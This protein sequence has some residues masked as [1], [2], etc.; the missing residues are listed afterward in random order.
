VSLAHNGVLFLDEFAEFQTM[1]LESLRQPI[2]D[3]SVTIS[4]VN[5][6]VSYPASFMVLASKNP[7][8]CGYY[9]D[10]THE[11]HCTQSAIDR[12]LQK[13]SGRSLTALIWWCR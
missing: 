9:N 12:Y 8:P 3:Q 1:A 7:C 10:P 6:S 2:E 4:R 13:I 5:A 11:C